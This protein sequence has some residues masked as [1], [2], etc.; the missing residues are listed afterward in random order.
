MFHVR[1]WGW[2]VHA[3]LRAAGSHECYVILSGDDARGLGKS[4]VACLF[5]LCG[6][7]EGYRAVRGGDD[8]ESACGAVVVYGARVVPCGAQARTVYQRGQLV[9]QAL[10]GDGRQTR[11]RARE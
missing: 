11:L 2:P 6:W 10:L 4:S 3:D 9:R 8:S 1:D 7:R 5:D